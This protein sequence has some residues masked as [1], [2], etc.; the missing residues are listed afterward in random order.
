[1][2]TTIKDC[3]DQQE[4]K[5][6]CGWSTVTSLGTVQVV[7][8]LADTG[9][10]GHTTCY[11]QQSDWNQNKSQLLRGRVSFSEVGGLFVGRDHA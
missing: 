8:G 1:M 9:R 5:P 6:K 4:L 2:N 11:P 10:H 3:S 7:P